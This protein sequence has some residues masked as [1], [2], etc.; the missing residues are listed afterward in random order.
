MNESHFQYDYR[1]YDLSGK[2][3]FSGEFNQ[4]RFNIPLSSIP[5]GLYFLEVRSTEG[6]AIKRIV[7]Q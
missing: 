7:K 4:A 2:L 6:I 5:K 1:V 3:M